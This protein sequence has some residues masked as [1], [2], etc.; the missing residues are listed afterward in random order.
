MLTSSRPHLLIDPH[1]CEQQSGIPKRGG[2]RLPFLRPTP[3]LWFLSAQLRHSIAQALS[4]LF[5]FSLVWMFYMFWNRHDEMI[6]ERPSVSV[7][8]LALLRS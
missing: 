1:K 5:V 7:P 8:S 2:G 3:H 6:M 4:S